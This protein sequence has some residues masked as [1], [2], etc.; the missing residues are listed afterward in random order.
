MRKFIV[1]ALVVMVAAQTSAAQ[2]GLVSRARELAA[3]SAAT[4]LLL[5]PELRTSTTQIADILQSATR[6]VI[7]DVMVDKFTDESGQTAYLLGRNHRLALIV[8][9]SEGRVTS[10][11]IGGLGGNV[12]FTPR[13]DVIFANGDVDV[14]WGD[15]GIVT[16]AWLDG[17]LLLGV[18]DVPGFLD[19]TAWQ[20][21]LRV[22]AAVVRNTII[23]D[24]FNLLNMVVTSGRVRLR[25]REHREGLRE[26]VC[27][28]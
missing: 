26:L 7:Q 24:E 1:P 10:V 20:D 18:Q 4:A 2:T 19:N 27:K 16:Q 6:W 5:S 3:N 28:R 12:M 13:P 15:E 23:Q 21:R 14:R 25:D 17:D 11:A 22:R 8:G 9:C